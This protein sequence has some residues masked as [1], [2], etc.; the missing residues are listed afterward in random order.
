MSTFAT[1]SPFRGTL[2]HMQR[3]N[4]GIWPDGRRIRLHMRRFCM[5]HAP[6][7]AL[8]GS[9][10]RG[11]LTGR[12]VRS[13]PASRCDAAGCAPPE[14]PRPA[15]PC[16]APRGGSPVIPDNRRRCAAPPPRGSAAPAQRSLAQPH[17]WR[18]DPPCP[19]P[20]AARPRCAQSPSDKFAGVEAHAR[21]AAL[22][23][24]NKACLE[25]LLGAR[26]LLVCHALLA[27]CL[28]LLLNGL[29]GR[30]SLSACCAE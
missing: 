12:G 10:L 21:G 22:K 20:S 30:A 15:P 27:Q 26:E 13:L 16:G 11:R 14:P 19:R 24:H 3:K 2:A 9:C 25:Q 29:H 4:P 18:R 8:P 1:S 7:P 6:L 17:Q 28:H 23:S 5:V